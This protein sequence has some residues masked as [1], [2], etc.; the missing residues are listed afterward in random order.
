MKFNQSGL[1]QRN[2]LIEKT[3]QEFKVSNTSA[4]GTFKNL[5][6][7]SYRDIFRAFSGN[8]SKA[9]QGCTPEVSQN[10]TPSD[11][12]KTGMGAQKPTLL[13]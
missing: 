9:D 11:I 8:N 10:L 4:T 6:P 5:S 1:F 13:K 12:F 3:A 2:Q 7:F